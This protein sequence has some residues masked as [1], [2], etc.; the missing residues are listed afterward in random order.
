MFCSQCGTDNTDGARFCAKCG[1]ALALTAPPAPPPEPVS[2]MRSAGAPV[3]ASAAASPSGKPPWIP[4][5]LS[6]F[7]TGLGQL[8]NGDWKKGLVMFGGAVLGLMFTA[9]I[10]TFGFWIWGMVDAY[11]VAI[12]KGKV[13]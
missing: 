8:Y 9:G 6:L 7:V 12:G 2:T 3:V 5:V 4:V 11:Q 10:A 1:A 13:W